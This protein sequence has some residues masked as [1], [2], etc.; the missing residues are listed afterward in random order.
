MYNKMLFLILMYKVQK[1]N[2]NNLFFSVINLKSNIYK[3]FLCVKVKFYIIKY[4]Q[5]FTT[6]ILKQT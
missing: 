4:F 3:L 2:E 1:R 5:W 6:V